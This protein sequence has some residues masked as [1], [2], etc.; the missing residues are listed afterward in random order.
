MVVSVAAHLA[1]YFNTEIGEVICKDCRKDLCI[2]DDG[3]I[4]SEEL[5]EVFE[6][7]FAEEDDDWLDDDTE[8][9]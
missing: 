9:G 5:Q 7:A 8:A 2:N 6:L 1:I 3:L 4:D